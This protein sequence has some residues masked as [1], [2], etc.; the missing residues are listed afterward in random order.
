MVKIERAGRAWPSRSSAR[1]S[2]EMNAT[3]S[4]GS[5]GGSSR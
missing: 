4:R 3:I 1:D 2:A 5:I